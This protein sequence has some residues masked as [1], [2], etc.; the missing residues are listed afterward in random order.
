MIQSIQE[1]AK[2]IKVVLKGICDSMIDNLEQTHYIHQQKMHQQQKQALDNYMFR[3]MSQIK[4][5][6]YD[7]LSTN[8]YSRFSITHPNNIR[9]INYRNNN[10]TWTYTFSLPL[11]KDNPLHGSVS[12]SGLDNIRNQI[13][14]DIETF[15]HELTYRYATPFQYYPLIST[16]IYVTNLKQIGEELYMEITVNIK[17]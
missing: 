11:N 3:F 7:I 2:M 1:I 15:R 12:N 9:I 4:Y 8:S 5:E 16:G 14:R 10:G 6:L 17:P 13:Q